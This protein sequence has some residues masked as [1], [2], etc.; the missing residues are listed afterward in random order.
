MFRS[1]YPEV[2]SSIEQR[3]D[4]A[5]RRVCRYKSRNRWTGSIQCGGTLVILSGGMAVA[6]VKAETLQ[7]SSEGHILT[8]LQ[9]LDGLQRIVSE[10]ESLW[11]QQGHV[12]PDNFEFNNDLRECLTH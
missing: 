3:N 6:E 1:Q 11:A 9:L 4:S 8:R 2:S 5:W 12:A 10:E 7:F